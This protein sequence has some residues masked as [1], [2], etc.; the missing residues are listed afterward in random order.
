MSRKTCRCHADNGLA[1]FLIWNISLD[2][3]A[4]VLP[5]RHPVEILGLI[6]QAGAVV[7]NANAPRTGDN[8]HRLAARTLVIGQSAQDAITPLERNPRPWQ[9]SLFKSLRTTRTQIRLDFRPDK[10]IEKKCDQSERQQSPE[11]A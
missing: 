9:T 3:D 4:A 6:N 11:P 10:T 8:T 1:Q 5:R 7:D 2:A